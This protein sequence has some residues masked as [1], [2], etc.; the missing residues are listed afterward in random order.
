MVHNGVEYA[1]LQSYAEGFHLLHDGAYKN[2]NLETI[3]RI[4]MHG[5]II[6]SW[7]LNLTHAI[8]KRDQAFDAIDGAIQESGMGAWTVQEAHKQKVPTV[9]LEDAIEL[10]A[11][12]RKT[13]GNYATKLVALL[14][15]QFGGHRVVTKKVKKGKV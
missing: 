3:S 4:W 15:H 13:G 7:I 11:W 14:R 1:L 8:F 5:S 10:R 9:L 2:L 12:S 6:R